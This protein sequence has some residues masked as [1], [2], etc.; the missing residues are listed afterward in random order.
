MA[1]FGKTE[2]TLLFLLISQVVFAF[3]APFLGVREMFPY[4]TW[5]L[6][7]S[8]NK[9]R[10]IPILY[11]SQADKEV[12]NPPI[13]YYQFFKDK[14]ANRRFLDA[15]DNLRQLWKLDDVEKKNTISQTAAF[16]FEDFSKVQ[17]SIK[18]V[19]VDTYEFFQNGT[20]LGVE[21]DFG[22]SMY[23]K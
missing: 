17:Y 2:K 7:N 14:P 13:T 23:E 16:L 21:Q 9:F 3:F 15:H 11:I 5:Q 10:T 12:F 22:E 6:F 1:A 19:K 20:T 18:M 4:T 8:I